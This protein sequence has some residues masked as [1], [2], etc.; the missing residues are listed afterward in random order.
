MNLVFPLVVLVVSYLILPIIG[1]YFSLYRTNQIVRWL[2]TCTV[3]LL[4]PWLLFAYAYPILRTLQLN[5]L[6]RHEGY[7]WV[8]FG[9]AFAWLLGSAILASALL[10]WNLAK[11]RFI[12]N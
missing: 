2:C 7:Y 9:S 8:S 3:G 10:Y 6:I 11:R 12:S 1:L 5:D 4:I